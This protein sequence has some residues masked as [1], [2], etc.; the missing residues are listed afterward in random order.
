MDLQGR[1]T[2]HYPLAKVGDISRGGRSGQAILA[3][4]D[5]YVDEID[6]DR[7]RTKPIPRGS[8]LFAKIGE[9]I[10]H[11]H[12][13]IAGCDMLIDNN[14]MA[15][16]PGPAVASRYLYHYLRTVDF[17]RLASATTVPA[18]RKSELEKIAIPLPPMAEQ[19]RIAEVLDRAEA[20]RAKR[21]AALSQLDT[22]TQSIFLGLFGDPHRN[23]KGWPRKPMSELFAAPPI[24]GSMIPPVAE[25][26]GWLALRVGNIQDWTLDFNDR[27]YVDLPT[28]SVERHTVKD[29]D[30]LLAR[31]IASEEHLGK[32]VVANP[33]DEHWA[34]DSHLMRLRFD[35][36]QAE[37]EF[38]RHLFM[39]P[40]GR[41]L[42]LGASRKSTVQYNINT[43]EISA[44]KIPVPPFSLQR[45]FA[46]HI[47]RVEKLRVTHRI[48]LSE[49]GTLF[50]VLQH[51]AFRGEL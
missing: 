31:A 45:E 7:L 19:R 48:S 37:P 13:V 24:F 1:S 16:I 21:R 36:Q 35:R 25:R 44:L 28:G 30:L 33:R 5:H 50:A 27:K 12:R 4:S 15:A 10:S 51:R 14:A 42:F 6:L 8:I 20:L 26:R 11:N 22:L 17:Y 29:G 41:R 38:I 2:G 34:F 43:K 40:G 18:L 39:T 49:L 47:A 3:S 32:C 9:A 46:Q 23:Q